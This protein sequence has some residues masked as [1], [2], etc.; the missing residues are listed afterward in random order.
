MLY[1]REK[2]KL[3]LHSDS[4]FAVF[5]RNAKLRLEKGESNI[6][7]KTTAETQ[8]GQ[9]GVQLKALYE[10]FVVLQWQ[11]KDLLNT[12][13]D[14]I[15]ADSVFKLPSPTLADNAIL[16]QHP[17]IRQLEQQQQVSM[18]RQ[19][20]EQSRLSP[21][22]FGAVYSMTMKGTGADDKTYSGSDRFQSFQL[23]I[24]LPVFSGAQRNLIAA[25]RINVQLTQNNYNQG[26][27]ALEVKYRQALETYHKQLE[28]VSYYERSALKNADTIIQTANQ[29]FKC[30][31]INYLDW[32][33]LT[34][35]AIAIQSEYLDAVRDLDLSIIE[36]DSFIN[37]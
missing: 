25:S 2:Q 13:T 35:N 30:G 7:E 16:D 27:Q 12:H 4:I 17:Y 20:L 33:L 34:N 37:Q 15:P 31:Q 23:G 8:S 36:I 28:K 26:L 29:Q 22:L 14:F 21:D 1:L 9:I 19:R 18:A 32:V 5:L 3:L 11:M 6:L 10:D 24:G